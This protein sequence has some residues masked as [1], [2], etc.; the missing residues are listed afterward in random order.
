MK[1]G[2]SK[3]IIEEAIKERI[4]EKEALTYDAI[5]NLKSIINYHN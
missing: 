3:K 2:I 5:I 4:A 1:T